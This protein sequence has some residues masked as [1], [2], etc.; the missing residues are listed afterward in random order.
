LSLNRAVK[1]MIK[2]T[3]VTVSQAVNMASL[4]PARVLG[5]ERRI[6]S[7]QAGKDACLAVFDRDFKVLDTL[8]KGRFV[9]RD[10]G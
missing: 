2:W 5:L 6:G 3:G 4:N 9:S 1:N 8:L 10:S 7:I